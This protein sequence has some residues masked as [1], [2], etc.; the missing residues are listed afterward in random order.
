MNVIRGLRIDIR[1]LLRLSCPITSRMS[2]LMLE[3]SLHPQVDCTLG[4]RVH[5]LVR[6]R[7][8]RRLVRSAYIPSYVS[9]NFSGP[10]RT[11]RPA[12]TSEPGGLCGASWTSR[13]GRPIIHF[14]FTLRRADCCSCFRPSLSTLD[15]PL[16]C[17]PAVHYHSL[18]IDR[19]PRIC[20]QY[21]AFRVQPATAPTPL[22]S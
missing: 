7:F 2:S 21:H 22:L 17:H 14:L 11:S 4:G 6:T 1:F 20:H 19:H 5:Y 15:V 18:A 13:R 16:C 3:R 12:G 10:Y 9:P 8:K